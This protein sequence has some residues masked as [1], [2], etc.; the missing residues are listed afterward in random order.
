MKHT[1]EIIFH[2]LKE[3]VEFEEI[4]VFLLIRINPMWFRA[5][6]WNSSQKSLFSSAFCCRPYSAFWYHPLTAFGLLIFCA[7]EVVLFFSCI[8]GHKLNHLCS[9]SCGRNCGD[10]SVSCMPSYAEIKFMFMLKL[11]SAAKR[12]WASERIISIFHFAQP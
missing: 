10:F 12:G 11:F 6:R 4:G 3:D 9:L 7:V 8:T 5:R 2:N 1:R